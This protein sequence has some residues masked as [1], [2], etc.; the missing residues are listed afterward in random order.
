[1]IDRNVLAAP[2][3]PPPPAASSSPKR[4]TPGAERV[5]TEDEFTFGEIIDLVRD[6]FRWIWGIAAAFVFVAW[7]YVWQ[8]TPIYSADALLQ[9]DA[10]KADNI[11]ISPVR[12]TLGLGPAGLRTDSEIE[13][14]TSR[15]ALAPVVRQFSLDIAAAPDRFPV[16]GGL[17]ARFARPGQPQRP[18]FGLSHFAWGGESIDVSTL[19]VPAGMQGAKLTLLA[20]PDDGFELIGPDGIVLLRGRVGEV[21][22]DNGATVLVRKLVARPG[23][24]F[25]VVRTGELEAVEALGRSVQVKEV[26]KQS[27]VLELSYENSDADR[28]SA[29]ANAVIRSYMTQDVQRRQ[30]EATQVI[31]F[32]ATQLP[33]VRAEVQRAEEALSRYQGQAGTLRPNEEAQLYLQGSIAVQRQISELE[34]RRTQLLQRYTPENATVAALDRQLGQLRDQKA[35]FDTRFHN[36]PNDQRYAL[37]LQRDVK[38]AEDIYVA[39]LNKMHE[40]RVNR[41]GISGNVHVVD[42]ALRPNFPVKPRGALIISA[43]LVLGLA[44]GALFAV[45]RRKLGGIEDAAYVERTLNLPMFGTVLFSADQAQWDDPNPHRHGFRALL[46]N[47]PG[48][49]D[50]AATRG[51]VPRPLLVSARPRDMTVETLRDVRTSMQ[52]GL[53]FARS[54]VIVVTGPA[55]GVGKSFVAAN[56][57]ALNAQAGKRVLL[58]DADMRRG[59]LG[60][61]FG[62]RNEGGLSDLISGQLPLAQAVRATTVDGLSILTAGTR[63]PNPPQLLTSRNFEALLETLATQY[64]MVFVDTP[65]VLAVSDAAIVSSVA[66]ST[67]MVL[68]SGQHSER[69]IADALTKLQRSGVHILGGV[70]NAAPRHRSA[71][72]DEAYMRAYLYGDEQ[73]A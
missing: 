5:E 2:P 21:A 30:T 66:G 8:A 43:G 63:P 13:L 55:P 58:V 54:P 51:D 49:S 18:W 10:E 17:A 6:E 68:R 39:L 45:V 64:D 19:D 38:V 50:P 35:G 12:A 57:A 53:A 22:R 65:P 62:L 9:V 29:I 48:R 4:T 70:L 14:L 56:L 32:L 72:Y 28:A 36:L 23:T 25:N 69:E 59:R 15:A 34:L 73:F 44:C 11:S 24:R 61:F 60:Q 27:S 31:D 47:G 3:P 40:L 41:A 20:R 46:L 37:G 7:V 26:G 16:L 1:M 33:H 42:W 71:Q 52:Y 67:V